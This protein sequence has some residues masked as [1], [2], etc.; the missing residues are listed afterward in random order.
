MTS[1]ES[2]HLLLN[3]AINKCLQLV[4]II[5]LLSNYTLAQTI[6]V[7]SLSF[8]NLSLE[9]FNTNSKI[10]DATG[11]I[12]EKNSKNYLVTNLHVLT[13]LD[14]FSNAITDSQQRTPTQIGIWH[15]LST[16]GGWN[17]FAESLYDEKNK[18]R[19]IECEIGGKAIDLVAL[20][21][22]TLPKEIKLYPLRLKSYNDSIVVMP[23]FSVSIIGFPYGQSSAGSGKFAIWK[24]GHIAS[25]F[26]LDI[27]RMPLFLIDATTRPGMSGAMVIFRT[28]LYK[29][30]GRTILGTG[31]RFL[32]VYTAQSGQEELGYVIKP[33]ALKALMD[34]LP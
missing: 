16:L 10:S 28:E 8:Q 24:T 23:G 6:V 17:R 1:K 7:D 4:L 26:D 34:K 21:L 31:T 27:N 2:H 9:L 22:K 15:N 30:N 32:G 11:F 20:P 3:W 33:M 5:S 13:G 19:W 29:K 12:I 18:K 25:D 14:Y